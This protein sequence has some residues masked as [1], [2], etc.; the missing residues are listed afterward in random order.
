[1]LKDAICLRIE[2]LDSDEKEKVF[3][4]KIDDQKFTKIGEI[5]SRFFNWQM[6]SSPRDTEIDTVISSNRKTIKEWF[7][8]KG[9]TV[10][11]LLGGDE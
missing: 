10:S 4:R 3:Y 1:M 9:L 2:I 8:A 7:R 5:F 11:Y 6:W